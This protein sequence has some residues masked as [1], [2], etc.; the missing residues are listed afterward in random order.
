MSHFTIVAG[1]RPN[2]VARLKRV[3]C[4]APTVRKVATPDGAIGNARG[5]RPA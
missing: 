3:T 5:W 1:H 4:D 2:I